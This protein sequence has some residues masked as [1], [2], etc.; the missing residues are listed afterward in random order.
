MKF[1]KRFDYVVVNAHGKLEEA[2]NL[3]GSI[4][5]A[6]KAKVRQRTPFI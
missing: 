2:V 6:E 5:D 4:I 3:V 1:V